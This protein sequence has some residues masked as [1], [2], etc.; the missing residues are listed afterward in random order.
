MLVSRPLRRSCLALLALLA[1][2]PAA[3]P[4]PRLRIAVAPTPPTLGEGR[5]IIR[6]TPDSVSVSEA[7][8]QG[9]PLGEGRLGPPFA[10]EPSGPGALAVPAFPF[11]QPGEWR[12]VAEVTL[13]DGRVLR[14]STDVRVVGND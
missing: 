6:V 1:C 7:R 10:A 3:D 13:P 14:D 11:D 9:R 12:L 2:A 4:G 8:I 5:V